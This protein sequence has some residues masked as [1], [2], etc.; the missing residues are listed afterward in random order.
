MSTT[1]CGCNKCRGRSSKAGEQLALEW[2]NED[3]F[4]TPNPKCTGCDN[5]AGTL[6]F[7]DEEL[8]WLSE[9]NRWPE[10]EE[11][12]V[13]RGSQEYVRWAQRSLNK[14]LGLNLAVDGKIGP[15]TRNAT[16]M[17]QL[18]RGL[19]IDGKFGPKTEAAMLAAGAA[20]PPTGSGSASPISSLINTPLPPGGPGYYTTPGRTPKQYGLVETIRAITTIAARWEI[21]N[22]GGP[23]IGIGD[24]SK[25]GGGPLSGHASH[26]KGVDV[27]IRLVRSDGKE[28]PV[29]CQDSFYSPRLTQKLIN[30]IH[31]NGIL[32]VQ[33]IFCN[34]RRLKG[35]S[36]WPNH[37]N[38]LHVRF[39]PP[40]VQ[41]ELETWLNG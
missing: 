13:S 40:P 8:E 9:V 16:R 5:P 4:E 26:Q 17:F 14:I 15:K 10:S 33:Y 2:L 31:A 12:E 22:P 18:S 3:E 11:Q 24:I 30:L 7:E 37:H 29:T 20:K 36:C 38:H 32:K 25:K 1:G 41:A 35:V 6:E 28:G 21:A 23:R 19:T 34:D 39:Y 27:D